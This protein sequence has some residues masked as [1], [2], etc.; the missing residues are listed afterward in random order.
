MDSKQI[1]QVIEAAGND[2]ASIKKAAEALLTEAAV[3]KPG[4]TVSTVHDD[5]TFPYAGVKGTVV[6]LSEKGGG[7]VD[8]RYPDGTVVPLQANLLVTV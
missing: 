6:G 7:W 3:T 8:V 5:E 4:A 1:K 2:E